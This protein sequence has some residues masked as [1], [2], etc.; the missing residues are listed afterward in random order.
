MAQIAFRAKTFLK[1]KDLFFDGL[2]SLALQK[3]R[4]FRTYSGK[5]EASSFRDLSVECVHTCLDFFDLWFVHFRNVFSLFVY[6]VWFVANF[7]P[8]KKNLT[9]VCACNKLLLFRQIVAQV[10]FLYLYGEARDSFLT[11]HC[12]NVEAD[13]NNMPAWR[14]PLKQTS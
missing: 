5:N 13:P 6:E 10:C 12:N 11:S 4:V 9:R 3:C 7:G 2:R 8:L 1:N 14:H